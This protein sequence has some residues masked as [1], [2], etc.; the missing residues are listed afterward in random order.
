MSKPLALSF[1]ALLAVSASAQPEERIPWQHASLELYRAGVSDYADRARI[2]LCVRPKEGVRAGTTSVGY[3]RYR[4]AWGR[5]TDCVIV[6]IERSRSLRASADTGPACFSLLVPQDAATVELPLGD[7]TLAIPVAGWLEAPSPELGPEPEPTTQVED[8]WGSEPAAE[9]RIVLAEER[10]LEGASLP[11][12]RDQIVTVHLRAQNA[13]KGAA[14]GL[15]AWIE[16]GTGVF[17]AKDGASRIDLGDLAPG[18]SAEFVYRCYADRSAAAL[19]FQV[20]FEQA[21]GAA[22]AT[23]SVVSFPLAQATPPTRTASDVDGDVA[24][25]LSARPSALAVVIGVGAYAKA[26]AAT[27]AAADGKTAARY[28]E[29]A[30]GIPAARIEMLLDGE[31]TLGQLQRVFGAEGWLAR[32]ASTD[33]EIFVFFAG[34]GMA[35]AEKF[36]PYL[37][38]ADA[39]PNYLRQ[40][41]LSLDKMIEM[42]ASLGARKT[43]LFLDA[44]FSGLSREGVA[45]L[46]DARPL[47]VEQAPHVPAGLS[48]YSAGSGSQIVSALDEQGHGLFSYY[49]F[50]GLAGDADLDH[51]RRI[52]ASELKRYLEEAV[53][54]AAQ[55]LDREQAPGIALADPEQVLVQLP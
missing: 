21:G 20:T 33:T 48:I 43:T 12:P 24:A 42:I 50:K 34:H 9:P 15:A 32:R 38:P 35:E 46:D 18:A 39:D 3:P 31:A 51:D 40:T 41:A 53:P 1:A 6:G 4:T 44:C 14:R 28:F 52:V 23:G 37:L 2:E 26:P 55:S 8:P 49:L 7:R 16:P 36:S 25:S 47:L 29:R 13:G 10:S 19:S 54:R 45:L 30:L 17:A 22:R 27:F 11:V 5:W